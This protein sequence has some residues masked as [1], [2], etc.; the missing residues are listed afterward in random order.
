MD[1]GCGAEDRGRGKEEKREA[2]WQEEGK[3]NSRLGRD[4]SV[5]GGSF[6]RG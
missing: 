1:K 6:C 3:K 4:C 2:E 5:S